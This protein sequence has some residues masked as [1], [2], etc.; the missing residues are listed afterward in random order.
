MDHNPSP[1]PLAGIRVLDLGTMIAGPFIATLL[2]DFGA[3]VVKVEL[4]GRGDT[5]RKMGP[6]NG[7][8]HSYWF[9]AE[10]R[11]K[12][13]ITLDLRTPAGKDLLLRLVDVVDVVVENFVPG[14][15]ARWGLG[16]DVLRERNPRL[17]V[18]HAS[19]Y[20]QTGPYSD[21]PG[22]DRVG[23]A[24][25]GLWHLTGE[26][27]GE[28]MR[29]GLSIADYMTGAYGA[30]GVVLA[31]FHRDARG[32]PGQEVDA[33]LYESVFRAMEHT[34]ARYAATGTGRDREGNRG[35]AAPT[36][37]FQAADGRWVAVAVAEDAMYARLMRA[38]GRDDLATDPRFVHAPGRLAGRAVVEGAL[39]DWIRGRTAAEAQ[40]ALVAADIPAALELTIEDAFN[41][42][43]YAARE[44]VVPVEDPSLGLIAVQGVTPKLS[45][46]PGRVARPA[47]R[48]GEHNAEVYSEYLGLTESELSALRDAGAI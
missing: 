45:G 5:L 14:T 38:I 18:A 43:H 36:G 8:A 3:D 32:G 29:P 46:T 21:R 10:S 27:D 30:L 47:P 2:G 17:I 28:P 48:M 4:P 33:A 39:A 34:V 42:P 19:G 35:P 40:E 7:D 15:M 31:L 16:A 26:A 1:G 12:R 44:M 37:A 9:A 11:N 41:D 24:F 6:V 20:G 22:Y 13:S 25:G 23:V